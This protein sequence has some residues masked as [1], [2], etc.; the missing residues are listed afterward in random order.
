MLQLNRVYKTYAIPIAGN[1]TYPIITAPWSFYFVASLDL[2]HT[3]WQIFFRKLSKVSA[4]RS[5]DRLSCFGFH[6]TLLDNIFI[7]SKTLEPDTFT[8]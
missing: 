2:D 1:P 4:G 6:I 5:L 7:A 8:M 3:S